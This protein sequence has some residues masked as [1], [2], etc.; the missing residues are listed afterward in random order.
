MPTW[1]DLALLAVLV[2]GSALVCLL[3]LFGAFIL[4]VELV[5]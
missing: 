4:L 1:R 2:V 5:L 3:A